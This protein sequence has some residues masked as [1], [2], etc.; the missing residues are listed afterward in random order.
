LD[1]NNVFINERGVTRIKIVENCCEN[2]VMCRSFII[3]VER[4]LRQKK[5]LKREFDRILQKV[6]HRLLKL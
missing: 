3:I 6:Q 1:D 5:P 4:F 2:L